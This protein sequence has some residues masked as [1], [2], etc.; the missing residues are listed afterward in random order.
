MH[1]THLVGHGA[2]A[3]DSGGDVRHFF[4]RPAS[5]KSFKEPRR[6]IDRQLHFFDDVAVQPD[7]KSSFAFDPRQR[8]DFDC[9]GFTHAA[10]PFT[11]PA[12]AAIPAIRLDASRNSGAAALKFRS[13]GSSV[14]AAV[15]ESR[16]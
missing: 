3:A 15:P 7:V 16:Y 12:S 8:F 13:S 9:P 11:R 2:D 1:R 6:F 10:F 5:Q 14:S 4:Q